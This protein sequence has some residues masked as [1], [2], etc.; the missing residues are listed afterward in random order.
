MSRLV[1]PRRWPEGRALDAEEED[2]FNADDDDESVPVIS[3]WSR[4]IS[5]SSPL[6]LST[7][8]LKRKRRLAIGNSSKG[9]RPPLRTPKLGALVD[10]NEE[11]EEEDG[12]SIVKPG[13]SQMITRSSSSR[14]ASPDVTP[15]SPKLSHR[16]VPPHQSAGSPPKRASKD[17][18]D[19][20]NLLESL[21]RPKTRSQSPAPTPRPQ[22]PGPGMMVSMASIGLIR[23]SEKRRRGDDD[24]DELMERLTKAKKPD[25]GTQKEKAS[26][27]GVGRTKNGDDPPKKIKVK[28]GTGGLTVASSPLAPTS[29]KS[30]AKDGDTG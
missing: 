6:P 24:D 29:S 9:Y 14:P 18:D 19:E 16:Q 30:N 28:L 17:E 25:V 27:S 11:E 7:N 4:G 20:D 1:E 2:Y 13:P 5:D 3:Q 10:Y 23:P 26:F 21:V 15:A 22:S 8:L 12:T